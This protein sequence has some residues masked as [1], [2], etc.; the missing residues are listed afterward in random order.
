MYDLTVSII[1]DIKE[2]YNDIPERIL[3]EIKSTTA[4]GNSWVPETREIICRYEKN[5]PR[6]VEFIFRLLLKRQ[7]DLFENGM[8]N[9]ME[10]QELITD[11]EFSDAAFVGDGY[12]PARVAGIAGN[13]KSIQTQVYI[14]DFLKPYVA[15]LQ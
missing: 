6:E 1:R 13:N 10:L 4:E 15:Q 12:L 11:F 8:G 3:L 5:Y 7:Y 2:E 14:T 9:P